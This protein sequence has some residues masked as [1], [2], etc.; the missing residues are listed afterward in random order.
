[1][2][3]GVVLGVEGVSND[4]ERGADDE[5]EEEE[6]SDAIAEGFSEL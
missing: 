4:C 3:T 1:M 5:V 2:T 6:V